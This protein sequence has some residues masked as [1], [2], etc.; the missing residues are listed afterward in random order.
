M[1]RSHF[2]PKQK[3]QRPLQGNGLLRRLKTRNVLRQRT[4]PAGEGEAGQG[5]RGKSESSTR[6]GR[7]RLRLSSASSTHSLATYGSRTTPGM[8]HRPMPGRPSRVST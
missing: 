2:S 1:K 4:A 5:V 7:R 8:T 3:T 6:S